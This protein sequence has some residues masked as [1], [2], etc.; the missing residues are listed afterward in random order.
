MMKEYMKFYARCSYFWPEF[1]DKG[2]I[3]YST[4]VECGYKEPLTCRSR[5]EADAI[6]NKMN[7]GHPCPKCQKFHKWKTMTEFEIGQQ[8]NMVANIM[9]RDISKQR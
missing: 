5:K 4:V 2:A 3:V 7:K 8:E 9:N 6:V 1:H